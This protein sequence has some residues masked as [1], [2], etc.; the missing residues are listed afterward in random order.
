MDALSEYGKAARK[1]YQTARCLEHLKE[2]QE[3]QARQVRRAADFC[4]YLEEPK[5]EHPM[6]SQKA[7]PKATSWVHQKIATKERQRAT[8]KEHL[9][10]PW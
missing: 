3:A 2:S 9:M 8:K 7:R 5:K 10:K 4:Q 1:E 6:V